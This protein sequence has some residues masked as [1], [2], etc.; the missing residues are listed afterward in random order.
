MESSKWSGIASCLLLPLREDGRA[1]VAA[2]IRGCADVDVL[3]GA[4]ERG[5]LRQRA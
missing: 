2:G 4:G 1:V 5:A 3:S